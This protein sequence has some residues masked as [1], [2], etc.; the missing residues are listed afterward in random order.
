MAADRLRPASAW[1]SPRADAHTPTHARMRLQL[2]MQIRQLSEY[3]IYIYNPL[4][5]R[6]AGT[7]GSQRLSRRRQGSAGAGVR[8]SPFW[9]NPA[10]GAVG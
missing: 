10:A 1:C 5:C 3:A 2:E 4:R 7:T 8:R 6:R 9:Q